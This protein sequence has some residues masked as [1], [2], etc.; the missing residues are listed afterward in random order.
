[1]KQTKFSIKK[2][3]IAFLVLVSVFCVC[4]GVLITKIIVKFQKYVNLSYQ[5][6]TVAR[7]AVSLQEGSDYLTEEAISY[8]KEI[9]LTGSVLDF[10]EDA[11]DKSYGLEKKEL[12]AL[13]LVVEGNH[14]AE[15]PDVVIPKELKEIQLSDEDLDYSA[16]YKC[17]K[18]WLIMFSQEYIEEKHDIAKFKSMALDEIFATLDEKHRDS[19]VTLGKLFFDMIMMIFLMFFFTVIFFICVNKLIIS[20]IYKMINSI[21][22]GNHLD[23]FDTQE[24]SI[25]SSTYNTI[26]EE[27]EASEILLRHKAEHDELTGLINRGAFNQIKKVLYDTDDNIVLI[28][29]DVDFFKVINDTYGH[30]IGDKVLQRVACVLEESFRTSDFVARVG[31]DEFLI[32][33]TKCD[34]D[35]QR[36]IK[37]LEGKM[38]RIKSALDE[39]VNDVPAVTLSCGI[40]LSNKG[41]NEKLY[42]HADAALYE[43]KR[44]GRNNF[45]VY[46]DSEIDSSVSKI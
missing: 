36:T 37:L 41:Y 14:F 15:N 22:N 20:P 6:Y 4:L 2:I 10:F 32:L 13:K 45:K 46:D 27:N 24:M 17:A 9:N 44:T 39:A 30:M 16:E 3:N 31:G 40:A 7:S 19:T 42:E 8:L 26:L 1:M 11:L 34:P 29:V 25:L 35:N 38:K 5:Y 28:I 23:Q 18:A 43:V 12:Y 21:R 33:L